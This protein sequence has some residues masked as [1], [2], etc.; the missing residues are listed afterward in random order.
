MRFITPPNRGTHGHDRQTDGLRKETTTLLLHSWEARKGG[1]CLRPSGRR[2]VCRLLL[3]WRGRRRGGCVGRRG[4]P[5][6]GGGGS[7]QLGCG[8]WLAGWVGVVFD[9]LHH[10]ASSS[11]YPCQRMMAE[12]Q[13]RPAPNPAH[14]ITSPFFTCH[15]AVPPPRPQR[16]AHHQSSGTIMGHAVGRSARPL[17]FPALTASSRARGMEPA[18]VLP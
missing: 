1:A 18:L 3:L 5:T 2:A 6:V 14:A 13:L 4:G 10:P 15:T 8:W 16:H 17:T 12:P 11:P 9:K 7:R